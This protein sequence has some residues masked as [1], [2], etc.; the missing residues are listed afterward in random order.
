M[1]KLIMPRIFF[2]FTRNR[3]ILGYSWMRVS[4]EISNEAHVPKTTR[5]ERKFSDFSCRIVNISFRIC[6]Y[7]SRSS[8][9]LIVI[10]RIT[11]VSTNVRHLFTQK[12]QCRSHP[13]GKMCSCLVDNEIFSIVAQLVVVG[14]KSWPG[15]HALIKGLK[16]SETNFVRAC[17]NY[18]SLQRSHR[19]I[20]VPSF[21]L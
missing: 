12:I 2:L 15:F 21:S 10:F 20:R 11:G 17:L 14:F 19:K 13:V 1:I 8:V 18:H 5:L 7:Y 4:R 16:T 9:R 3:W 6:F